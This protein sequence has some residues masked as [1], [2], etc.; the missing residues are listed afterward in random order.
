MKL[1]L[2]KQLIDCIM[3][4]RRIIPKL[5]QLILCLKPAL[6]KSEYELDNTKQGLMSCLIPLKY[7]CYAMVYR[8][9][10]SPLNISKCYD[11]TDIIPML[12]PVEHVG[13]GC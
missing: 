3:I 13:L 7:V 1:A 8:Y 4:R 10:S 5:I 11:A 6:L 12:K 2:V 9:Q